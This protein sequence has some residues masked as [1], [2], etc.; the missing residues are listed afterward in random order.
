MKKGVIVYHSNI[1]NIYKNRWIEKSINSMINQSDNNFTFYEVNYGGENFS[2]IPKDCLIEKKFWSIN[3]ANYADAMN[4]ILN[5][6]FEAGCDYV[7]NTNLDDYYDSSRISLQLDMM[8]NGDYDILSS[9]FYYVEEEIDNGIITD[10]I[11]KYMDMHRFGSIKENLRSLH[12]V[13]AHP[14][15]CYNK[16]FWMDLNNKYDITKTPEEDMDLWIRSIERGYRFGI[17]KNFLLYYRRHNNQ[18]S[19]KK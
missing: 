8:V 11:K 18:V 14:A 1:K 5:K 13:I 2:V 19:V 4:F 6:A 16:R 7:F 10:N 3:L 15:V 12:N 17:H 9:N